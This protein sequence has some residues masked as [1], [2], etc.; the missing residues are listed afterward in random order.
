MDFGPLA[1][2]GGAGACRRGRAGRRRRGAAAA[3][4]A[5]HTVVIKATSYAPA[6]LTVR[7]GDTVVWINEDPFPHT[8]TAAGAFDSKSIAAGGSWTYKPMRAGEFAYVCT[9]H[10]NMKGTLSVQ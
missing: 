1:A 8:A 3:R 5:T 4:P 2:V 10:P 6:A 9:F 7:R